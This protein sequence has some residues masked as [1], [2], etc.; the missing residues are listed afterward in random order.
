MVLRSCNRRRQMIEPSFFN[1]GRKRSCC[2]RRNTRNM[3]SAA[4][5]VPR[6]VTTVSVNPVKSA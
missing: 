2:W 1:P 6:R 4:S 5:R 3:N